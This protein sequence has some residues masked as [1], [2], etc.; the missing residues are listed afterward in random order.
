MALI[1]QTSIVRLPGRR[2]AKKGANKGMYIISVVGGGSRLKFLCKKIVYP[3][4]DEFI[5]ITVRSSPLSLYK[6]SELLGGRRGAPSLLN[7]SAVWFLRTCISFARNAMVTTCFLK[8]SWKLECKTTILL[9]V[10]V[11]VQIWCEI[12]QEDFMV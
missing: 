4:K 9:Y 12:F 3:G 11:M 10:I 5:A 8:S 7:L 6:N 2:G 1:Y